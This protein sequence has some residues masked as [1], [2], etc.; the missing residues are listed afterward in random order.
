MGSL[1]VAELGQEFLSVDEDF[2][3]CCGGE[4]EIEKDVERYRKDL[5]SKEKLT[6]IEAL[7]STNLIDPTYSEDKCQKLATY[8]RDTKTVR[9][10][11]DSPNWKSTS[12]YCSSSAWRP[13]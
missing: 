11:G 9:V 4:R 13:G 12:R 8:D 7:T 6:V 10:E 3:L 5:I 2:A 1:L